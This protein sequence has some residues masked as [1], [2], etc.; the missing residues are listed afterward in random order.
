MR[1]RGF[2]LVELLVVI[3]II[4]ILAGLL[5]PALAKAREMAR[6]ASCKSNLKQI[7]LGINLYSNPTNFGQMPIWQQRADWRNLENSNG[8]SGAASTSPG[9]QAILQGEDIYVISLGRLYGDGGDGYVSDPGVFSCPS[10]PAD[11][12]ETHKSF[13]A[14]VGN[15]DDTPLIDVDAETSYGLDTKT[16]V[17][18]PSSKINVADESDFDKGD[19]GYGELGGNST[20]ELEGNFNHLD[21]QT[22]LYQDGHVV[23]HKDVNPGEDADD[24][25]IYDANTMIGVANKSMEAWAV[26]FAT[27]T[28]IW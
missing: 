21:G 15:W 27:Q 24:T 10:S 23:F 6:K 22:C 1:K 9:N 7:G 5:L 25:S 11:A 16:Q 14:D 26:G 3:A 28:M 19:S 13:F 2:T 8:P 17:N 12:P 20:E 4:A 18:D